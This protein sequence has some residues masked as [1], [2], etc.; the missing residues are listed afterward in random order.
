MSA[1]ISLLLIGVAVYILAVITDDFFIVSLDEISKRLKL[2][3]DVAGASLM[4][5][6]S[7][8]PE[9]FIALIAVYRGGEHSDLGI[10]TIVGSAVFNILVI[11]GLSAVIAGKM[12]MKRGAIERDII[13]Y[14]GSI[15]ILLF[16]FFNGEIL[17][18]EAL[19]MLG[20]YT[21]YLGLLWFW[22]RT[23]PEDTVYEEPLD[24]HHIRTEG[25]G[26]ITHINNLIERG[27]KLIARDPKQTYIWAMI[28]S[29]VAIATLSW[30][31]VES[32]VVF[33]D[34]LSLPPV[35]VALT[36]L[37]AGTSAPDLIASVNV[38]RDGRG[39]MAVANA[40]GSNIFD[41]LIGLGVPWLITLL[42]IGRD[43]SV[44]TDDLLVS[45]FLLSATTIVLYIFMNTQHQLTRLEGY[46]L[47]LVYAAYVAYVIFSNS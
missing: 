19:I 18:Y 9:L 23:N 16:V 31:L 30:V 21:V 10:G 8:A 44:G 40:V 11:T 13:F 2:P 27:F 43:V 39:G 35:I 34:A 6:G 5:A 1:V 37:A 45:V 3:S 7:S 25:P 15:A 41:I 42:L 17:L 32:A 29:I 47:L 46:L 36:L 22:S 12:L 28:I 24:G 20:A 33:S 14:M 38:A 26:L 4:A